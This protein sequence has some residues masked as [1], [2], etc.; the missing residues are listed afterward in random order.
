MKFDE[1]CKEILFLGDINPIPY[2]KKCE[3]FILSSR[4]EGV[5]NVLIEAM[6]FSKPI[7]IYNSSTGMDEYVS[8]MNE[9]IILNQNKSINSLEKALKYVFENKSKVDLLSKNAKNK[10]LSFDNKKILDLWLEILSNK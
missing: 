7:I 4:Y 8:D 1:N 10:I 2:F 9:A 5:P 3:A 6:S